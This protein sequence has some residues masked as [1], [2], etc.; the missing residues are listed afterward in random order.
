[1]NIYEG[2]PQVP[3]EWQVAIEKTTEGGVSV[4]VEL[5]RKELLYDI[6]NCGYMYGRSIGDEGVKVR[7]VVQGITDEGNVDVVT[8]MLD[9]GFAQMEEMLYPFTK[10]DSE[11]GTVDDELKEAGKYVMEMEL[12]AGVSKTSIAL[13]LNLAHDYLVNYVLW[14]YLGMLGLEKAAVYFGMLAKE[15]EGDMRSAALRQ[16]GKLRRTLRPF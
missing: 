11:G 13:I 14:R 8:R 15:A 2:L 4:R 16:S 6:A 7:D 5:L 12:P 1:M 10:E 9:L 3:Q